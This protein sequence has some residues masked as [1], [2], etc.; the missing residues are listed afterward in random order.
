MPFTLDNG[1]FVTMPCVFPCR[2][3][4]LGLNHEVDMA[5]RSRNNRLLRHMSVWLIS[6]LLFYIMVR[7]DEG[8]AAAL[9]LTGAIMLAGPLPVYAHFL[10]LRR[11]FERRRYAV[12]IALLLVILMAS[13][14]WAEF[15]H[16]LV[17]RD[18]QSHTNGLGIAIFFLTFSTGFRYFSSGMTQRYRI[19]EAEFKQLQAEM[20]LLRSQINPHFLFNSLNTLY[21]LSLSDPSRSSEAILKLSGLMRYLVDCSHRKSVRLEEEIR[22]IRDYVALERLRLDGDP[23]IDLS[24][25]AR[26]DEQ[27]I[28]PMLLL[29]FVE[30]GFK[31]GLPAGDARG[32]LF[33]RIAPNGEHLRFVVENGRPS[34]TRRGSNGCSGLGLENTKRRLTLL[35]PERH[36][37]RIVDHETVYRVELDLW[38]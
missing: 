20:A 27:R 7:H 8:H 33:I 5:G 13:S 31:H 30:N 26:P 32:R 18:P 17:D 11:F 9:S 21:A 4:M 6:W 25:V 38:L 15:V 35:Y 23:E 36:R 24:V 10:A 34:I 12:Y 37:L 2:H 16:R 3:A 14:V 22:F 28:A 29:P 1:P 19:Q